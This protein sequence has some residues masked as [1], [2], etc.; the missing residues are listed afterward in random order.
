MKLKLERLR[1]L[2]VDSVDESAREVASDLYDEILDALNA[3]R[4]ISERARRVET[5]TECREL[6]LRALGGDDDERR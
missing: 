4:I 1:E 2:L 3:P 5:S 6:F